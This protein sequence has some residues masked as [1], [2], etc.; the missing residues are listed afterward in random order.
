MGPGADLCT[1]K[2]VESVKLK[3]KER[4]ISTVFQLVT[5]FSPTVIQMKNYETAIHVYWDEQ[6]S[7]RVVKGGHLGTRRR[8]HWPPCSGVE[9]ETSARTHASLSIITDGHM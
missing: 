4:Y 6:L 8:L 9:L 1:W 3:K 7:T 2:L 5:F